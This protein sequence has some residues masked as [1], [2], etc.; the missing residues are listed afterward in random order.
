MIKKTGIALL[1]LL[2]FGIVGI[3]L[4]AKDIEVSI[5]EEQ[6]Q[7]AID[8]KIAQGPIQ[9]RGIS[10]TLKSASVDFKNNNTA[11]IITD[12]DAD[13]FGYSGNMNGIFATGI[14]YKE[15]KIFLAEI[16]PIEM[17]ISG[18]EETNSKLED[19]KNVATDFLKR[20]REEMLSDE[21]KESLDKIIG[22][23]ED[24]AKE[25]A[26]K[27]TYAFFESLPIYD[28]RDAGAAGSLASLALKDVRFNETNAIVTLSP[29]KA[30]IKILTFIALFLFGIWSF[31]GFVLPSQLF[32]SSNEENRA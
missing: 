28:L 12:F 29:V 24:K 32:N 2:A 6:V 7:T 18:S 17:S 23:N 26:I 10:L 4:F 8:A 14:R 11:E 20:Q 9:S 15:P 27:A 30:L 1:M 3:F 25:L 13:G 5:T 31:L 21:A 22:R 16:N 19:V